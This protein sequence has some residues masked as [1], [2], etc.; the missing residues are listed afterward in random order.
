MKQDSK[1]FLSQM[2]AAIDSRRTAMARYAVT[3][4]PSPFLLCMYVC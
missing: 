2:R 1:D 3:L 4:F